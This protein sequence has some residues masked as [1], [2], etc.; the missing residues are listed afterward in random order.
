MCVYTGDM[1]GFQMLVSYHMYQ[2]YHQLTAVFAL[3]NMVLLNYIINLQWKCNH[4]IL[5]GFL[6]L[7][8][9]LRDC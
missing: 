8:F 7:Y 3:S 5:G 6:Q 1:A 2:I 9:Q 4:G